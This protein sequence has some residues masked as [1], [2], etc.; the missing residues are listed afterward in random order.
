MEFISTNYY[1]TTTQV[2]VNTGTITAENLLYRDAALQWVSAGFS[3][4]LTTASLVFNF[5]QTVSLSRIAL[6]GV[7]AKGFRMFYGGLT[8]NAF[9]LSSGPTTTSVW[10]TNSETSMYLQF[11]T[12][13]TDSV[14]IE[15][16]TTQVANSDK[17]ISYLHFAD[18]LLNFDRI[19][20]AKNYEP[21]YRPKEIKH[22]LSDGGTRLH[23]IDQKFAASI[24]LKFVSEDF[25]NKLYSFWQNQGDFGFVPFGTATSWDEIIHTVVWPGIFDFFKYA[26]DNPGTGFNGSI[27]LEEVT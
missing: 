3:N 12:V 4:D 10:S 5:G 18:V 26:D 2:S 20:S 24:K 6:V 15:L 13:S 11:P 17:A 1:Q 27:K 9:A 21:M 23:F 8:A 25:R 22:K 14:T 7:N 19:P 16:S